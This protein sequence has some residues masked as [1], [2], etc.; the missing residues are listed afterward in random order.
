MYRK[1]ICIG[2]YTD[3]QIVSIKEAGFEQVELS[4]SKL[5]SMTE[6]QIK[7]HFDFLDSLGLRYIA[8]N[9][10]FGANLPTFFDG[11]FD[12]SPIREYIARAF[13]R[14]K[15]VKWESIAF[16]SGFMRKVPEGYP[17]EKAYEFMAQFINEEVV[18][19]LEKYDAYLNIEELNSGETNFINSCADA[20]KLVKMVNHPRI[21]ILCDFYHMSLAGETYEDLP[22]IAEYIGHVHI[23]SP[24]NGRV[25]PYENDGDNEKYRAFLK[26]LGDTGYK[27]DYI[28]IE[29]VIPDGLDF[30]SAVKK[31]GDYLQKE[32]DIIN[33]RITE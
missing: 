19:Y 18:P 21:G 28:S 29:S 5:A 33:A 30:A 25:F 4:F 27:N 32:L 22:Q 2:P 8:A 3:E 31:T 14:T 9:G 13:E 11:A 1:M 10:F 23:A 26:T 17:M 6:A 16:G 24:S 15:M 12:I 20:A 7:E